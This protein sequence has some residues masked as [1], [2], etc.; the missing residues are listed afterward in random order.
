[1]IFGWS[2]HEK[3]S[4][5]YYKKNN[6]A[7]TLTNSG[8]TSFFVCHIRFLSTD[9]KYKMNRND[10]FVVR[11]EKDVTPLVLSGE[12]LHEMVL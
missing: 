11:V 1:M 9:H 10:I 5:S 2:I 3:L 6:K 7:F 8:K 12:E 4:C